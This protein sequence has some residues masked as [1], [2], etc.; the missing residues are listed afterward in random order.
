MCQEQLNDWCEKY[1]TACGPTKGCMGKQDFF[2]NNHKICGK[3]PV[4]KNVE[5]PVISACLSVDC[6]EL[7]TD[8]MLNKLLHNELA[9]R[10]I[11]HMQVK[12]EDYYIGKGSLRWRN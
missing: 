5:T 2:C 1:Q 6:L 8:R 10:Y 4:N 12:M 3:L 11:H 7:K 9:A